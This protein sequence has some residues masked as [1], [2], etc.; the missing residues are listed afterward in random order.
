MTVN[1]L[2]AAL[3]YARIGIPVFPIWSALPFSKGG[4]ICGCG[5]LGCKNPA[6]HPIGSIAPHGLNDATTDEKIVRHYW[7][8]F[9]NANIAG[10][11]GRLLVID[12]DPRHDGSVSSLEHR[13]G[14][15]PPTWRANTG[16]GGQ[17]VYFASPDAAIAN[18]TARLAQ[19]VDTRGKGGYVLL[20]PSLHVSGQ[21]YAW[22]AGCS[23]SQ[24]DL[25]PLPAPIA[26]ALAEPAKGGIASA[27]WQGIASATVAEGG[28]NNTLARFAGHLLRRYVDPFV[29]RE[30]L[31]GCR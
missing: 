14:P 21:R 24:V 7:T 28:R 2:T 6:K 23:P 19:G 17:H 3:A 5:K 29:V 10:A 31:R 1:M 25:A 26:A 18:S 15:L 11:G 8:G 12:I 30:L 9:P 13:F 27:D 16:G 22:Q 4:F 20:P